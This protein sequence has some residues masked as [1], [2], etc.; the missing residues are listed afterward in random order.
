MVLYLHKVFMKTNLNPVLEIHMQIS[1]LEDDGDLCGC[2]VIVQIPEFCQD[3][4]L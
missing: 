2:A 3:Y 4:R 1:G